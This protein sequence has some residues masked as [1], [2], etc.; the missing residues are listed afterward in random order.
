MHVDGIYFLAYFVFSRL[1]GTYEQ[2]NLSNLFMN[3][4]SNALL[5]NLASN[6]L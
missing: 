4:Q 3:M 1:M 6:I 2:I 5:S